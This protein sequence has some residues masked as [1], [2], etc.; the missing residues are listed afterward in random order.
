MSSDVAASIM[1]RLL[2]RAKS[3]EVEFQLYLVRYACERFLYRLGASEQRTRCVLK[4]AGLLS[5]W[6]SEPY[7]M[8][9]DLDFLASGAS[10]AESIAALVR[11]ICAVECEEDGIVFDQ[12]SLAVFPIRNAEEYHG[13]RVRMTALLGK[14]RIRFQADFGFGDAVI[15]P[16]EEREHPTL[17]PSLPAPHIRVYRREVSIAE[18]FDA[19]LQLG[20]RNSRMKDFHDVWALSSAFAFEGPVLREAV[21]ACLTRRGTP[22]TEE[23]PDVLRSAFYSG[24]ALRRRWSEYLGSGTFLTSAPV[25]FDAIGERIRAFYVPLRIHVVAGE[26]FEMTWPPGGPW[27]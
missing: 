17:L 23:E 25:L 11:T 19:M 24:D 2:N 3:E 21:V 8:T 18:K 10:D 20:R 4:G 7:R 16:P 26:S 6:L 9:R 27:R 22:W 5:L 15:P 14:S 12:D 1:A 13:Q